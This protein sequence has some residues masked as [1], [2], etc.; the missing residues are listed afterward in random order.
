[1]GDTR[2]KQVFEFLPL[3]LLIIVLVACDNHHFH[4]IWFAESWR[5][6][7]KPVFYKLEFLCAVDKYRRKRWGEAYVG[8]GND[9]CF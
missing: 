5:P 6:L 7:W 2:E 8:F 9:I 1:M 4:L 3:A